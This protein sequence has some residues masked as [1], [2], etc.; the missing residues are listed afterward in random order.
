MMLQAIPEPTEP[1]ARITLQN[2]RNLVQRAAV[3]QAVLAS[4]MSIETTDGTSRETSGRK[5]PATKPKAPVKGRLGN[6]RGARHT[7][8][9]RRRDK[10]NADQSRTPDE[11]HERGRGT[12]GLGPQSFGRT[13]HEAQFPE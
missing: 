8:D 13:I 2:L 3:Q 9:T 1:T 12:S 10:G 6:A 4:Q 11:R 5:Y 7:L